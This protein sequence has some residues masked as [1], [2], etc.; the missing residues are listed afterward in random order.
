MLASAPLELTTTTP[1]AS[2]TPPL[3]VLAPLKVTVPVV[4]LFKLTLPANTALTDPAR[5]SKLLVLVNVPLLI[6]PLINCT[7]ATVSA[8]PLRLKEPP[9]T[10]TDV[11]LDSTLLAPSFKVP[12]LTVVEPV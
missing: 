12:A 3:N 8:K 1:F 5:T 6:T 7:P 4:V 2:D 11:A 10:T 9:L